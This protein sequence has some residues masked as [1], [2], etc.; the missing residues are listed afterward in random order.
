M[1]SGFVDINDFGADNTGVTSSQQAFDDAYGQLVTQGGG[2]L[3]FGNGLY[4][5][6]DGM[7]VKHSGVRISG[8]GGTYFGGNDILRGTEIR[9][10]VKNIITV[11]NEDGD[12]EDKAHRGF[13]IEGLLLR[14]SK[15]QDGL[16]FNKTAS[17]GTVRDVTGEGL[18][19]SFA[20]NES[21]LSLD[22]ERCN[23]RNHQDTGWDLRSLNHA[24]SLRGCKTSSLARSTGVSSSVRVGTEKHSSAV[25]LE[26]TCSFDHYGV[27]R[28]IDIRRA[29]SFV[30]YNI[31][32][33]AKTDETKFIIDVGEPDYEVRSFS[34]FGGHLIGNGK[35]PDCIRLQH[36]SKSIVMG[37]HASNF[38]KNRLIYN[39]LAQNELFAVANTIG[40]MQLVG[41]RKPIIL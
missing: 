27:S 4:N 11:S 1:L 6:K 10:D 40:Q 3:H 13:L 17:H 33:E 29:K 14:G 2:I 18:K 36:V 38:T 15:D 41:G 12:D 20:A 32:A 22:Y 28:Q 25:S 26:G 23:S 30:G 8:V 24:S 35:G 7:H 16:V 5:I 34:L 31:Y 9:S 39:T 21:S 37:V 19:R